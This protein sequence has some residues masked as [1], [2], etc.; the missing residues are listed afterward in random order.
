MPHSLSP[1]E[2]PFDDTSRPMSQADDAMK[3]EPNTQDVAM[4]DAD[5]TA[6][7]KKDLEAMFDGDDDDI[8]DDIPD[9]AFPSSPPQADSQEAS[10]PAPVSVPVHCVL[11]SYPY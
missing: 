9:D 10:Q 5:M 1:R 11:H 4:D 6:Q 2:V 8:A 7:T 3:S